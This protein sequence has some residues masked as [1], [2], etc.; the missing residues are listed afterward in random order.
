M[1]LN[2][3]SL[4]PED[5]HPA[6]KAWVYQCNRLLGVAE[7]LLLEEKLNEFVANWESHGSAV[8][9]YANLLFGQFVVFIADDSNDRICGRAIDAVARF[10]QELNET[11]SVNFLDRQSLAFI[12]KDKVQVL[13]LQ[14]LNY[15]VENGFIQAD[16]LYF[17]NLV[18][19]KEQFLNEWLVPVKKS[20]LARRLPSLATTA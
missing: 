19:T 8:K 12:V 7:A 20:W 6:S 4:I 17:N 10:V 15:A 16:T 18:T 9:G 11:F 1:N 5:L 3:Q 13:P 14:Q 2:Y